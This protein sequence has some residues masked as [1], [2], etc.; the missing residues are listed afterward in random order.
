[1]TERVLSLGL[2]A[3]LAVIGAVALGAGLVVGVTELR[4]AYLGSP[5]VPT[6]GVALICGAI[7][8]GGVTLLRGAIRGRIAFRHPRGRSHRR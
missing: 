3:L 8:V 1:M 2:R 4:V 6:L 5:L 7:V